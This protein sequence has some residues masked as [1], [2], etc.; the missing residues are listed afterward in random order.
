MKSDST[1]NHELHACWR[2]EVNVIDTLQFKECCSGAHEYSRVETINACFLS[3]ISVR[4]AIHIK[5][6]IKVRHIVLPIQACML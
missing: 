1:V 3:V 6:T 4:L 2:C 5:M